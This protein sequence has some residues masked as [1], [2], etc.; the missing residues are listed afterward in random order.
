[1]AASYQH[2]SA[3]RSED[4]MDTAYEHRSPKPSAS[5]QSSASLATRLN[6]EYRA[7]TT[8]TQHRNNN[9]NSGNSSAAYASRPT[10]RTSDEIM[11]SYTTT[12]TAS[13]QRSASGHSKLHK[14]ASSGS[15]LPSLPSPMAHSQFT[16]PFATY[17]EPQHDVSPV[18]SSTST[19]KLKLYIRK[20]S[21]S[22]QEDQGRLD[23][24]KSTLE[25]ERLAGL[26]I[27]ELGQR[28]VSDVSISHAA[29]RG[30]GHGRTTSGTSQA[31]TIS[32]SYKPNLPFVHPMRQTPRPY[33]N[34]GSANASFVHDEEASESDDLV[35]VDDDF[36]LGHGFRSR[37]SVSI[38]SVPAIAPT[39]LSQSVTVDDLGMVPKLTSAS[40]TNL[41][42]KS[43]KS[44]KS[45]KSRHGRPRRETGPS[46]EQPSSRTSFDKAFSF[47]SR[48]SDPEP[49]DRDE[50]IRAARRKFEEKEAI[51]DRKLE[52][53]YSKRRQSE[54]AKRA[55]QQGRQ[56]R[57]SE[58]S[59]RPKL[60]KQNR[61]GGDGRGPPRKDSK[62][63]ELTEKV[64]SRSYDEFRPAHQ[65]SLP[66]HG[67]EAG[68]SEKTARP[69]ARRANPQTGWVKFSAW[70]QTRMLKC[71]GR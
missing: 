35:D 65:M 57:K 34:T 27:Q 16:T 1:M 13:R 37:R 64:P 56:A 26:G 42:I 2:R 53:E 47:V 18:P 36:R 7:G 22:K 30:T 49:R 14:R 44:G 29:R 52:Q 51:K 46:F 5:Q 6:D 33:G 66:R 31:S 28:S 45:T 62:N 50:R 59:E 24:S 67:Q 70:W 21:T 20:M 8:S 48:R 9:S 41:S 11:S 32:G 71:G 19:P 55:K 58:A 43:G 23:L 3:G 61:S 4:C 17:E 15:S 12:S 60:T 68:M 38:S 40:Q 63:D 10:G 54:D 39:P 69:S 25:N